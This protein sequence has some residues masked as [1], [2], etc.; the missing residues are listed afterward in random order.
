MR[1]LLVIKIIDQRSPSPSG[2]VTGTWGQ[3]STDHISKFWSCP[4]IFIS[5]AFQCNFTNGHKVFYTCISFHSK[6]LSGLKPGKTMLANW[7]VTLWMVYI[8]QFDK[9]D[10]SELL[11]NLESPFLSSAWQLN[12]L[13]RFMHSRVKVWM[14]MNIWAGIT[15]GV[16]DNFTCV[17]LRSM[18]LKYYSTKVS[19]T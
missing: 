11:D 14:E 13:D 3:V 15:W 6:F 5:G 2:S 12:F 8:H 19:V 9:N 4:S 18:Y 1:W 16:F 10:S 7:T 17:W